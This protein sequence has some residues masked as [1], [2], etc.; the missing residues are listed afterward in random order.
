MSKDE[1][2][3]LPSEVDSLP[4]LPTE[5]SFEELPE[6]PEMEPRKFK[7]VELEPIE[8]EPLPEP[9]PE[10]VAKAV[11]PKPKPVTKAKAAVPE[12][13]PEA[14]KEEAPIEE[15]P[16]EEAPV[17]PVAAAAPRPEL[18]PGEKPPLR[19]MHGAEAHLRTAA[20][21]VF[22]GSLLPW[23]SLELSGPVT[24]GLGKLIVLAGIWLLWQSVELRAG[25]KV[26]GFVT[27]LGSKA[28][29]KAP[30]P[31]DP[32]VAARR[33]SNRK[34]PAKLE[35]PFPTPLHLL[36]IALAVLGVFMPLLDPTGVLMPEEGSTQ[37]SNVSSLAELGML[38]WAAGTW[39]HLYAYERWGQFNPIFPLMFIGMLF[40]G[41]L[42][43][44]GYF[45]GAEGTTVLSLLGG[46]VVAIGGGIA[47]YTI[48]EAMAEAKKEGDAKKVA[49][50]ER[51][52]SARSSRKSK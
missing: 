14:P 11:A 6:L 49:E 34:G 16:S 5:A 26:P 19:E 15:A 46:A 9:E 39:V 30:A 33:A 45:G 21:V 42:T 38:A 1:L 24:W 37:R 3:E 35:I 2:P 43:V 48:V 44:V 40:S 29:G 17:E 28:I 13:K 51:R 8:L 47:A 4:E 18:A 22:G 10:P 41:G 7:A 27:S 36:G 52:Q 20:L 31:V 23:L 32:K 25:G 50:N 12:P